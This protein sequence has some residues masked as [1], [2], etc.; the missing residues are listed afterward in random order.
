MTV[1]TEEPTTTNV[2]LDEDAIAEAK[3]SDAKPAV[4]PPWNSEDVIQASSGAH[5][6]QS[7]SC[8]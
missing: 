4:S 2:S 7:L 1:Q 3:Q 8:V 5:V 6:V